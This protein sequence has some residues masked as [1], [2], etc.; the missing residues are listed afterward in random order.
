MFGEETHDKKLENAIKKGYFMNEFSTE[1]KMIKL[2]NLSLSKTGDGNNQAKN[3]SHFRSGA[4]N[5]RSPS[6]SAQKDPKLA[7]SLPANMSR[8]E[9]QITRFDPD[10][11]EGVPT[12]LTINS[13]NFTKKVSNF[14]SYLNELIQ[15]EMNYAKMLQ[16]IGQR[17][18]LLTENPIYS[19]KEPYD[20]P[21]IPIADLADDQIR[22]FEPYFYSPEIIVKKDDFITMPDWLAFRKALNHIGKIHSDCANFLRDGSTN[23]VSMMNIEYMNNLKEIKREKT[24]IENELHL[25][26]NYYFKVRNE[27]DSTERSVKLLRTSYMEASKNK[28]NYNVI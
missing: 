21:G 13:E 4:K 27:H 18:L 10:N 17:K 19:I 25:C 20:L 28:E 16:L 6:I 2:S 9:D 11:I 3:G 15:Y 1:T 26:R 8:K 14:A 12:L 22:A 24:N 7:K 23:L 5:S